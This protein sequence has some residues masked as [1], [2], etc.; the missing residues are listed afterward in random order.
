[1]HMKAKL[2]LSTI[3]LVASISLYAQDSSK[4]TKV[5]LQDGTTFSAYVEKQ[6]DGGYKL[7]TEDGSVLI[8]REGEISLDK[9]FKKSARN[10]QAKSSAQRQE[11]IQA[12]NIPVQNL[13]YRDLKKIYSAR[14]YYGYEPG[15]RYS[16][17]AIGLASFFVPGLGQYITGSQVGWGIL[18]TVVGSACLG[19]GIEWWIH[20]GEPHPALAG[21]AAMA[22][23]SA[24]SASKAAKIN[25]LY[26]R[27]LRSGVAYKFDIAPY[28][29]VTAPVLASNQN[30]VTGL[31]LRVSF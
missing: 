15:D 12:T 14:D 4:L 20:W 19:Y 5:F 9:P 21:W 8:Y 17:V 11:I 3:F 1:M 18:Q 6:A 22:V 13:K 31:S 23:W 28:I 25:N 30:F 29:N 26:Y 24:F 10:T 2:I 7:T 27:D 16:P